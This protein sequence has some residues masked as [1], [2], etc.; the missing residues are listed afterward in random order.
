M[1]FRRIV[2]RFL[3]ILQTEQQGI[4][5]ELQQLGNNNG[6]AKLQSL[7]NKKATLEKLYNGLAP[8]FETE[9]TEK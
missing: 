5:E 9:E 7:R 4:E 8:L 1:V 3:E 6:N 2:E